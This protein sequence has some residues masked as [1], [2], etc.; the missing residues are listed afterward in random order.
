MGTTAL[1]VFASTLI[2]AP[3]AQAADVRLKSRTSTQE[4]DGKIHAVYESYDDHVRPEDVSI[5]IRKKGG[6]QILD[7]VRIAD[8][9]APESDCWDMEFLSEPVTLPEMGVYTMDVV[10]REGQADELVH[11][12]NGELTYG[13]APR[14]TVTSDRQWISYDNHLITVSGTLVAKDPNTHEVKPFAG[15][16][17][18]HRATPGGGGWLWTNDEGRFTD[19]LHFF[20]DSTDTRHEY[21]FRSERE[22]L[23]LPFRKQELKL[24]VDAPLGTV[25]APYGSEV[26]MRGK[27]TRIAD[28]GTEK[29]V[30]RHGITIGGK[31]IL[32]TRKDGTFSGRYTVK[33]AG[34]VKI[35]PSE[36]GWFNTTA[37][38]FEV[39][40]APR[41]SKFTSLKASADKDRKV[42][43]T[44]KLGVTEGSYPAGT[45]A[46]VAMEHSTDNK[47]WSN[48]GTFTAKYGATFTQSPAKKASTSSYWR[49]RHTGA[50]LSST[51]FKLGRKTTQLVDDDLTPEGV[52]KGKTLTAK[53]SLIQKSGS[54]WKSFSGQ[55]VRIYFKA[56]TKGATWKKLGTTKTLS[57]GTFSKK[58]TAQ[59]DGTWQIRYVDTPSTHYADY[60][61]EDY[62]DVR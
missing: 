8:R 45:T 20:E 10:V 30:L 22:T 2:T 7:T 58:F 29:P 32:P 54:S 62:I 24:K 31:N 14:L 23:T 39:A 37:H 1:A 33:Q 28:D 56:S 46:L 61:R 53:G 21:S 4:K 49:L 19:T 17:L 6:D 16:G 3:A 44:G 60:G 40:K 38:S 25:N 36:W 43:F 13:L 5:R 55:T 15:A 11:R 51:S 12:D 34:T 47:T 27:L 48:V 26:P 41:T 9:C 57:N 52:R 59:Q 18:Y 50:D 35:A 42:T